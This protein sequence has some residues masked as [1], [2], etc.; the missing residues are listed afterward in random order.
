MCILSSSLHWLGN[1]SGLRTSDSRCPFQAYNK[2]K[3]EDLRQRTYYTKYCLTDI[4]GEG[5]SITHFYLIFF[6]VKY[7]VFIS[8]ILQLPSIIRKEFCDIIVY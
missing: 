8:F 2:P 1:K 6:V 7:L 3:R 5:L 4:H